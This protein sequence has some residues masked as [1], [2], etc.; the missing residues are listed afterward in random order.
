[1]SLLGYWIWLGLAIVVAS[2]LLVIACQLLVSHDLR[3]K[4]NSLKI[5][6]LFDRMRTRDLYRSIFFLFD[7][8]DD[9]KKKLL[10]CTPFA[11]PR[12]AV[13]KYFPELITDDKVSSIMLSHDFLLDVR[14]RIVTA[15]NHLE[16]IALA[17]VHGTADR[18]ML[19]K[20]LSQALIEDSRLGKWEQ[21]M[22]VFGEHAWAPLRDL[23]ILIRSVSDTGGSPKVS[24]ILD[25]LIWFLKKALGSD[26]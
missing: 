17:Y 22:N 21:V 14:Y 8:P 20:A 13:S 26:K 24:R 2:S 9:G 5:L 7:L 19:K 23:S 15:L 10:N 3:R 25:A 4:E 11:A 12:D 18:G 16:S 6:E 1:M